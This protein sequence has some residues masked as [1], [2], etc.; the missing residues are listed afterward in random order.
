[1]GT[2]VGQNPISVPS[3]LATASSA[4]STNKGQIA[5]G[6]LSYSDTGHEETLSDTVNSYIQAVIQNL[7]N[8]ASASADVIV[9]NDQGTAT[10]HYGDLGINSSGFT[11]AGSLQLAGAIYLYAASGELVLGT[12]TA[13]GIRFVV[14]NGATDAMAIDSTGVATHTNT[15]KPAAGTTAIVPVQL[16]AGTKLTTPLAGGVEFDTDKLYFTQAQA[17][18]AGRGMVSAKQ[19][20]IASGNSSAATTNTSVSPF[21]A[22]ND[23]LSSI[24]PAKLYR[25]RGRYKFTSTFTSGTATVNLVFTFSNAPASFNYDFRTFPLTPA[26]I[27]LASSRV[28]TVTVTTTSAV[29]PAIAGTISYVVEFEGF[30]QSHA[31]LAATLT[32][33]FQMST[34]GSST[35][36]TQFSFFEI[37]KIG[38][39]ADTLIAGN[40]A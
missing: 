29:T 40:W 15:L 6:A 19:M 9:A 20:V 7:S 13:N 33:Q 37:E 31:T 25:F 14:N 10:T 30:F 4:G 27:V 23:V 36:A 35:V 11:G 17:S 5:S 8:G 2:L 28:G 26:S 24:E 21:A 39:T 1:M 38:A 34:T 16:T 22:A 18:A 12:L 3:V 32:P